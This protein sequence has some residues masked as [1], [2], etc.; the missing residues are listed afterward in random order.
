M[1]RRLSSFPNV[2]DDGPAKRRL[3]IPSQ[4]LG[5]VGSF[6]GPSAEATIMSEEQKRTLVEE[7]KYC[8][9]FPLYVIFFLLFPY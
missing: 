7:V 4:S 8:V 2:V 5:G 6:A 9:F 1:S 3:S